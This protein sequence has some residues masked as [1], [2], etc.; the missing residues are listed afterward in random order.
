MIELQR[1][2]PITTQ[3]PKITQPSRARIELVDCVSVARVRPRTSTV[4]PKNLPKKLLSFKYIYI[5][6]PVGFF[7][8]GLEYILNLNYVTNAVKAHHHL[9]CELGWKGHT[10]KV[11]RTFTS[12][13]FQ[14]SCG[15]SSFISSFLQNV[16]L[17][18]RFRR[19]MLLSDEFP[20]IGWCCKSFRFTKW[21]SY[22]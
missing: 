18:K 9:L 19:C 22:P 11:L 4:T 7:S 14:I 15:L 13:P 1:S 2:I 21:K 12:C 10:E 5:Y 16:C 17:H 3:F 8:E 6:I 20:A